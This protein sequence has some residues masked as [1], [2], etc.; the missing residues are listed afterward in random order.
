MSKVLLP[1]L[2]DKETCV[3]VSTFN[4]KRYQ[5]DGEGISSDPHSSVENGSLQADNS[6]ELMVS[7]E[8]PQR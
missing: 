1:R 8:I 7:R 6:V 5:I 4:L 2:N 3:A